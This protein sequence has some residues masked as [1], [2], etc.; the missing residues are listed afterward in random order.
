MGSGYPADPN[1]KKWLNKNLDAVMGYPNIVRYSWNT[2]TKIME[3]N[4]IVP[5]FYTDE[6]PMLVDK[7]KSK[8]NKQ[9]LL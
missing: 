8:I 3:D 2:I 6:E 7:K 4:G 5:E 9:P 1:T